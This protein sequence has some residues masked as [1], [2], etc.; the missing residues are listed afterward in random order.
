MRIWVEF[1]G[2][3][4]AG[5]WARR[6]AR[7]EVPDEMPYGLHQ[8]TGHGHNVRARPAPHRW[9]RL[10][11]R[12]L[13][14]ATGVQWLEAVATR[15]PPGTDLCLSWDE[16]TGVARAA[17]RGRRAS[18]ATGV[19]WLGDHGGTPARTESLR[20]LSSAAFVWVLS[21]PQVDRL[22]ELGL[23]RRRVRHLLFGIDA[24][25]FTARPAREAEP[26]LF[27]SVGN[28]RHRDWQTLLAA[29]CRVRS[30]RPHARLEVVTAADLPLI[31]GM[32]VHRRLRHDELRELYARASA[33]VLPTTPN[34]HVSGMTAALEAQAMARPV[35]LSRTPGAEDYVEHGR[36]GYL[37]PVRDP[38]GLADRLVDLLDAGPQVVED[39]G[40]AGRRAVDDR[41][42]T[43]AQA[44]R[45]AGLMEEHC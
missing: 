36:T 42:S 3:L 38:G 8:L 10:A 41:L 45:L 13:R 19:I 17:L 11:G 28:D 31:E 33:V 22:V 7:G 30:V 29:F 2:T 37:D 4:D 23:P 21:A 15:P 35:V 12:P 39:L 16:R 25:F 20:A 18:V 44:A 43:A 6:H 9:A 40:A 24:D 27:A 32:T 1:G 34:L 26:G 5:D 14:A